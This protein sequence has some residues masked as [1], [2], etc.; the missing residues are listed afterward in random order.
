MGEAWQE[1]VPWL[2]RL[3]SVALLSHVG[4]EIIR[5]LVRHRGAVG[6]VLPILQKRD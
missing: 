5:Q 1:M 3:G 6:T 2:D 4:G